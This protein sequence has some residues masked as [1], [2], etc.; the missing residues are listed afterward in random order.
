MGLNDILI[1]KIIG[2][3]LT[4]WIRKSFDKDGRGKTNV[5]IHDINLERDKDNRI[6]VMATVEIV[7]DERNINDLIDQM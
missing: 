2:N 1:R 4:G 3:A 5:R 7:A 6:H